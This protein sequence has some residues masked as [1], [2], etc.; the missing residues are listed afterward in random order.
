MTP[1]KGIQ[2]LTKYTTQE[3]AKML[4][5]NYC[6]FMRLLKQ[7]KWQH[8]RISQRNVFFTDEDMKAIIESL[9]VNAEKN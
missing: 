7:R 8:H 5:L 9:Q 3:A 4:G 2:M 6:V 1:L